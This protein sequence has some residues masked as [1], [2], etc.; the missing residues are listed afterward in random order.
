MAIM[1]GWCFKFTLQTLSTP[2]HVRP[3]SKNFKQYGAIILAFSFCLFF[4][5]PL[6]FLYFNHHFSSRVLSIIL[7][8]VGTRQG[9]L[10]AKPLFALVHFR[11]LHYFLGVFLLCHIFSLTNDT[12]I[13]GPAHLVSLAFDHYVS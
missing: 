5:W 2:F 12:H 3:P 10:L 1:I 9:N 7:Y 13:L 11:V 8:F 4:L 6:I